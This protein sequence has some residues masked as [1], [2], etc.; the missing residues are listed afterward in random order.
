MGRKISQMSVMLGPA[1]LKPF[2]VKGS[3]PVSLLLSWE[4]SGKPP[5]LSE[6]ISF[7]SV[8]WAE[9]DDRNLPEFR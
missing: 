8:K 7:S 6:P 1:Y 2:A 9:T 5:N 4:T 3:N